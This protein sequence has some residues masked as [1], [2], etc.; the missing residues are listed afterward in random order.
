MNR[1]KCFTTFY[2][3]ISSLYHNFKRILKDDF[4]K[5]RNFL[6]EQILNEQIL[7]EIFYFLFL[8][9]LIGKFNYESAFYYDF[10][11]VKNVILQLQKVI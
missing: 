11:F 3:V 2:R 4:L 8:W 9:F 7:C 5:S 6:N 1:T 10:I